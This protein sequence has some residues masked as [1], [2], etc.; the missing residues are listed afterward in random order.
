MSLKQH[1]GFTLIE[2][3]VVVAIIGVLVTIALPQL[4][5]YRNQSVCARVVSDT[6][7]AMLAA[8]TEY[9]SQ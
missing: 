3:L 8:S 7:N 9:A 4:V 6:T 2:L 1:T 5:N